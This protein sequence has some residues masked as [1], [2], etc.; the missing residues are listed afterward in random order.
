MFRVAILGGNIGGSALI[1]LLRGDPTTELVGVY[2]KRPDA[3]GVI[4]ARKWNIP[5]IE[6]IMSIR[7]VNPEIVI[8]VT[9]DPKLSNEIRIAFE[10][11][12]EVIEGMGARFLWEIIEKQK[13][14]RIEVFK[15][16]EDQKTIFT[17]ASKLYAAD[18]DDFLRFVLDKAVELSESPAGSIAVYE[19]GEMRLVASKGL[20]KKFIENKAWGVMS[21]GLTEMILQNKNI[22]SIT[23]TLKEEHARNNPALMSEKIRAMLACPVILRGEVAGILYIDDFRP[24]QFSERQ[25]SSLNLLA[26]LIG[27]AIDRFALIRRIEELRFKCAHLIEA[28]NDMV[29]ITDSAGLVSVFNERATEILGYT[30]QDLTGLAIGSLIKDDSWELI[31][32]E[33]DKKSVLTGYEAVV[34]G[35]GFREFDARLNAIVL[36]DQDGNPSGSIFVLKNLTEERDLMKALEDKTKALEELNENLEK[37]VMERTEEFEKINRELERANQL[38]GRFIS[39]MSH[40]LRTPLNSIIGF[41]DVLLERTFG[42]LSE[43]QER[44]VKNI[45]SAGKHLLE[46]IN[47]VLDIAKIE[48]G[49]YEM[50]YET[51]PIGTIAD[52]VINIMMP[53]A[54]NKFIEIVVSIGE[55]ISDVTADKV[56]LK[57]ILYNL[58]SNAIK[59]TPE[60]GKVGITIAMEEN[61]DGRYPWAIPGLEFVRFSVWDTGIGI[62]PEDKEKIFDEFE[63][64][65]S[66]FSRKYGGVGLGLAL[67]KKL[68]E[69]HGGNITLESTLGE[70]STFSFLI[71]VTSPVEPTKP[72]A[73][74]AVSLNFPWMKEEAPLILVVEDDLP[75]AELLTLHLTQSGYKVA[76]AFDGQEALEKAKNL[77]PFAITLD[78]MLPK[79]DGWEVLQELK[80]DKKTASIPVIIHSIVNNKELAFALGATDY[81]LKPLEK[82]ALI[83]KLEEITVVKGRKV[84]PISVLIIESEDKV[85]NY[86]KEIFEPQGFL[87]YTAP[88]GKRGVE[89]ATALRPGVILLDFTLPDMLCYDVIKDIK[90]NPS[91]KD[92]PIFILTERD[93]SVEDRISLVGKI[94]RIVKKQA[95][96]TKELVGHIKELEML[97][98]RRAGLIDDL[99]GLFSHR[100]FQIRLA[101]EVERATRYKLPLNLLILDLDFF[102]QYVKEHGE[103]YGNL[104]IEKTA[105]LLRKNI[106]GSDVVVRYGGDSFAIILPNTVITAGLSLSNRF[107]AIIRNYPFL[108]EESQ[109]KGRITASVGLTFLDNQTT[110]EFML[111]AEKALAHAIKKGGDRV[112]VYSREQD[113]TEEV[114]WF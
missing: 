9:G 5:V 85:T 32:K 41:S 105:E 27:V 54:E 49:K 24:R 67:T 62:G 88:N 82:E 50:V 89:L 86:L 101:Q 91:T 68:V 71:P 18:F 29:L 111:C 13:R 35:F 19:N 114:T 48:A 92:I 102:G 53:L 33:L 36:R 2:E 4:L 63:Q 21:G 12:V 95:F 73:V 108:Y 69:L 11:K 72:E 94:E 14:A 83:L 42:D 107:A 3:P 78:I 80:S 84:L 112:E 97:Y 76:H 106:R 81:L 23:D 90:D 26:G 59:F 99:T 98:P 38:K 113:E 55:G 20:S 15:I 43:N 6:D 46:L 104:V 34:I 39:N 110:E 8:N 28:T 100:Y 7:T 70:G 60:G 79:K 40:E 58:L 74:D 25:K 77:K 44:Y 64:A 45:F 96:D 52:E 57:Q 56:K 16:A 47:N 17:A 1:S 22:V 65:D 37:K 51:F 103:Y 10:N 75:T 66:T 87:M 109:P 61:I 30:R 31:Q 93:I